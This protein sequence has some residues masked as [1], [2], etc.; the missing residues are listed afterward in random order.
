MNGGNPVV[1]YY[2]ATNGDLKL[3]TCTGGCLG[4]TP[5]WVI[6]TVDR[7]GQVGWYSSL[8]L[9]GGNPVISYYDVGSGALKLATCTAACATPAPT[10]VIKTIDSSSADTGRFPSLQLNGG[11]PVIGYRDRT[12]GDLK[13]ATCTAACA[14]AASAWVITT[15]DSAGDVGRFVSMQL[16]GDRPV[17]AYFDFTNGTVKL[18]TCTSACA[19]TAPTWITTVIDTV[20][21]DIE[22]QMSLRL[23]S[24]N[25]IV[26]YY[27]ALS[28]DLKLATC[29]SACA[30]SSPAWVITIVDAAGDAGIWSSLQLRGDIPVI[31]Y[32]GS[33]R[34][35]TTTAPATACHEAGDLRLA[36]C[37][38]GCAS[39]NPT[40]VITTLDNSGIAGWD[41]SMGRVGD[42]LLVSYHDT[43][44][45]DLKLAVTDFATAAMPSN[46][47][48]LWWNF[49]ESGWGINFSHQGDIVFGTLFTYDAAGEPMWLVM[50][51]GTRLAGGTFSG[52]LYRTTGPAFN[53]NP[54][55]PI[56]AGNLTDVG[57]MTVA[58]VGDTASVRYTANGV[59]VNKTVRKQ[60]FGARAAS[61]H[62]ATS[63]RA[64][65]T[66]YQDLW[67]NPAE[68]GWGINVT[69]QGDVVFATLFTYDA[70]GRG[71]WFVLSSGARQPDGSFLGDL[72]RTTGPAFN[73]V[74]FRP[75]GAANLTRVGTMQLRFANGESAT[76]TYT[77]NGVTVVKSIV[78]QVFSSPAPA[79]EA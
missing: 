37:T 38:A 9:D 51:A 60:V 75:I 25:P 77:V 32:F 61:C 53:A 14:T 23:S 22:V 42:T 17:I 13:L 55:T 18:A 54:F 35:C 30:T 63:S 5:T 44:R 66:N 7:D 31:S 48:A 71:A 29:V 43:V 69:H 19:S 39:A 65:L 74:P 11:N 67:W 79:C 33:V 2:D 4:A 16:N 26:S 27:D 76:L 20:P 57:A 78:R 41:P 15:V 34:N 58:F 36:A 68:S 3:A 70:G 46:Y 50:S 6:T 28:A 10:W 56:G 21:G 49:D 8:Q 73:A 12:N 45:G 52:R 64:S 59:S 24:G 40:W 47:T 62:G 1:S 72:Y